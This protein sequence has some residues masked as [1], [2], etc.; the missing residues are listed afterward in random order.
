MNTMFF[1][2][3]TTPTKLPLKSIEELGAIHART[4]KRI[5]DIQVSL[6]NLG[7]EGNVAQ[8]RLLSD[9]GNYPGLV[10]AQ[11]AFAGSM[12]NRWLA[13]SREVADVVTQ[14]RDE[15]NAWMKQSFDVVK[16][17]EQRA[18]KSRTAA[19]PT[20]RAAGRKAA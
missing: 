19:K 11:S 1:E 2:S 9:S 7:I 16:L 17:D 15:L 18:A 3:F 8:A 6:A 20:R 14:T 5:A 12:G 13:I 4:F 10:A